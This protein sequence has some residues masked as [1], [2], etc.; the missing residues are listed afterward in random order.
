LIS[1]TDPAY[2][3]A[4]PDAGSPYCQKF[5]SGV[6]DVLHADGTTWS[7]VF[8]SKTAPPCGGVV[9]IPV[10]I[11]L[12]GGTLNSCWPVYVK[13]HLPAIP[14]STADAAA[15]GLTQS[16]GG[17]RYEVY[18]P[19]GELPGACDSARSA[20]FQWHGLPERPQ[21]RY[22]FVYVN[23]LKQG[24]SPWTDLWV[25]ND[26]GVVALAILQP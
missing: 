9:P 8:R 19:Q 5:S 3:I 4:S 23:G 17:K 1:N 13:T 16:P 18:V 26:Q 7:V 11:D 12:T 6:Y 21:N 24:I 15:C 25:R 22:G 2:A 10:A 14:A 20:V